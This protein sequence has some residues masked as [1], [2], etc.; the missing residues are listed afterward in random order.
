[1]S[2]HSPIISTLFSLFR[3]SRLL[4]AS[5]FFLILS[6]NAYAEKLADDL[7]GSAASSVDDM[8]KVYE[9][10]F[11]DYFVGKVKY[12]DWFYQSDFMNFQEDLEAALSDNKKGMFF[13]FT[14]QGCPYCDKFINLSL[15]DPEI[16]KQVQKN[17]MPVGMEIFNDVD[18]TDFQGVEK[19]AKEFA[20]SEGVQFTP[21]IVFYGENGKKLFQSIGYQTPERFKHILN[22]VAGGHY[23]SQTIREYIK[24]NGTNTYKPTLADKLIGGLYE[25]A[26]AGRVFDAETKDLTRNTD[27]T[28]PLVVLFEEEDCQDCV[29]FHEN[30]LPIK[31]VRKLLKEFQV[32][33]LDA[34]D[35]K[36]QFVKP[37]KEKATPAEWLKELN[38][39]K[40]PALVFFDGKGRQVLKT[41]SVIRQ[42]RM[43][44]SCKYVLDNAFDK[45]WTYQRYGRSQE[46][47][48]GQAKLKK[49]EESKLKEATK[50]VTKDAAQK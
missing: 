31:K 36:T 44:Y 23:A 8:Q 26:V 21:T 25:K 29:D 4:I 39:Q 5:A 15:K 49:E 33:K 50:E 14:T 46:I 45:G 7:D 27:E 9:D 43:M 13:L 41:D 47:E 3:P 19:S 18:I 22:Y 42:K 38:I 40:L 24:E 1:M 48:K 34:N 2:L 37:N 28:R 12:P 32:V 20:K 11:D 17:F 30:I 6:C 16:A 35:E 10:T